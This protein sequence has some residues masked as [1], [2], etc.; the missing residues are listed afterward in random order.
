VSVANPIARVA[1]LL[2]FLLSASAAATAAQTDP[3]ALSEESVFSTNADGAIVNRASSFVFPSR[4]ADL[5]RRR[6]R[7]IAADDVMV[8]Y[9]QRGGGLGDC[10]M[11]VIVYPASRSLEAEAEDVEAQ[12]ASHMKAASVPAPAPIPVSAA[13]GR[14]HWYRGTAEGR[15]FT[16]GYVLVR[17]GAWFVLVRGSNPVEAGDAGLARLLAG[18]AAVDWS[19]R[20]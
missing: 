16:T 17:R 20:P 1:V 6:V 14:S 11:D 18:I 13:D 19:W 3:P 9:T 8:Q 4:L 12:I 2:F 15:T 7:I 10:W 5:P